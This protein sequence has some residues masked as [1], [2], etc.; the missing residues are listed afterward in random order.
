MSA[1]DLMALVSVHATGYSQTSGEDTE[2]DG[3]RAK[4]PPPGHERTVS[5]RRSR[6]RYSTTV[7]SR[8]RNSRIIAIACA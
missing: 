2:E 5:A 4:M 1:L 6:N 7:S 8:M 3:G